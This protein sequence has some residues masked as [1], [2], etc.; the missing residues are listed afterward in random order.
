MCSHTLYIYTL[1]YTHCTC[2]HTYTHSAPP[3]HTHFSVTKTAFVCGAVYAYNQM[4]LI[5]DPPLLVL[6]CGVVFVSLRLCLFFTSMVDPFSVPQGLSWKI[7]TSLSHT[8]RE[9]VQ[10]QQKT[11]SKHEQL[12]Q[13][14]DKTNK[15][16]RD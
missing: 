15:Q 3:T 5:V 7:M 8:P 11:P 2:I 6:V 12:S 16:K 14:C 9:I 10:Q 1:T 4:T 13:Q